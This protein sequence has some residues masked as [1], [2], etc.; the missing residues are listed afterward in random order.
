MCL[1]MISM[2]TPVPGGSKGWHS[3]RLLAM[4]TTVAEIIDLWSERAV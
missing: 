1:G 3:I 2:V 4:L